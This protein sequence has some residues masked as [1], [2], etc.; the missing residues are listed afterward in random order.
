M[1]Q[2]LKGWII[3]GVVAFVLLI[4]AWILWP[5]AVVPAGHMGV[6]SL[7]GKVNPEP[8]TPGLS[9][10]APLSKVHNMSVQ[11]MKHDSQG[12]AASKDLQSV[13]TT[14]TT[15]FNIVPSA[16]A[17]LYSEVGVHYEEKLFDGAIQETFKAI[18][19]NYTA[20]EL[21]KK[22]EQVTGEITHLFKTK[23][24]Q[25]SDNSIRIDAVFIKNFQFG[26]AF[27]KAIEEKQV[28]EQTALKASR[29]LERIKIE[30]DQARAKAQGE[31]DARIMSA[32]AEAESFRLK[33]LQITEN[34]IRMATV[35]KWDGNLPMVTGGSV[36]F[37]NIPAPSKAAA[38]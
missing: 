9:I 20:E 4:A 18:T 22:R 19:A 15:N 17:K 35:E 32:K 29:D 24:A 25:L 7:F 34:M 21:I 8:I 37:V 14:I 30:A 16:A 23:I 12:D 33:S 26:A 36:P 6:L 13:H 38:Q 31:A 2:E 11:I 1:D 10:V 27:N 5:L 3:K 28:A